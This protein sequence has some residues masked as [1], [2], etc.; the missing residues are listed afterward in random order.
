MIETQ[1]KK[2]SCLRDQDPFDI[3]A[4]T[5]GIIYVVKNLAEIHYWGSELLK[6]LCLQGYCR[7]KYGPG[8]ALNVAYSH[9]RVKNY[10]KV[11]NKMSICQLLGLRTISF[12]SQLIPHLLRNKP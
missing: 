2:R 8:L 6:K 11:G 12:H 9:K 1:T 10:G 3:I 5:G 4:L 7:M